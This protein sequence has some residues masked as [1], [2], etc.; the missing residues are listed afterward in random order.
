MERDAAETLMKAQEARRSNAYQAF[1]P[2]GLE[3]A[4]SAIKDLNKSPHAKSAIELQREK[5]RTEQK[6]IEAHIGDAKALEEEFKLKLAQVQE[7]QRR[8]TM[9]EEAKYHREKANYED[10]LAR[11]RY[12]DQLS[13]NQQSQAEI[14]RKQEESVAKQEELRRSSIKY[15]ADLRHENEMK[16]VKAE[17][18]GQ[19][20]V[21]R[22][23]HDLRLEKI[24]EES[25]EHR[26]TKLEAVAAWG[27]VLA[28]GA[29]TFLTDWKMLSSTVG[30]LSAL[31]VGVYTA[32]TGT[33]FVGRV[34]E[35]RVGKPALVRETSRLTPAHVIQHP[36][37]TTKTAFRPKH[38]VL[39]G[40]I[41]APSLETRLRDIAI[42][43]KNTKLNQGY[44]RNILLHGP[45]G[46]GKT[47]FAKS[48]AYHSGLDYAILTGGDI[49]PMGAQG[50]TAV[51]KVFDWAN[52]SSKG[53]LLFV[54]EADAFL[55][56]R[57]SE[58][59][60]EDLRSTLNAFLFRTGEQSKKMML[61]LASNQPE[62]FDWAMND[63]L[64][65]M[66]LFDLPGLEER[67]RLVRNYFDLFILRAS[68]KSFLQRMRSLFSLRKPRKLTV[69]EF[70][71]AAKCS[72]VAVKTE[73]LSA[74]EIS[75][76]AVSWQASAYAS[77]DGVLTE[78]IVDER[79]RDAVAQRAKKT[80]WE[81]EVRK[82]AKVIHSYEQTKQ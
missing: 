42:A 23:N 71:F 78:Q 82:E 17:L 15:E 80:Q 60:S 13:A 53:V 30:A 79:V 77:E 26:K 39:K 11:K 14:L 33:S 58:H 62:Q 4:A 43:T 76:L 44:Y 35:A 66:V 81:Q 3:R 68:E 21:E 25:K 8:L 50:V 75:K 37:K 6:R 61:V 59:I 70:D 12:N 31:A 54:D 32:R 46:S 2:E 52:T 74:R 1:D 27:T 48:L 57:S 9:Q 7:E 16:R 56:K 28:Q 20:Q 38:D 40:I 64:D 72:E 69:G 10:Q 34:I 65:E 19:A 45:P 63:R 49:S 36:V 47:M 67:E 5:E 41:L 51:H 73:G 55:R 22:E 18:A 24:R 29:Q